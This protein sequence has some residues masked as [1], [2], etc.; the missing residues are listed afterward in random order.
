[1]RASTQRRFV[2]GPA[3][4]IECAVDQPDG[5]PRGAALIAHPHP[6][7]G[8]TLDNKVVQTLARALVELGYEA[9]RPNFR[10]IGQSEGKYDEGRGEVGDLAAVFQGLEFSNVVLAG[11]SFGAAMQARL[12][13]RLKKENQ[14]K[15]E[16]LLLVGVAVVHFETPPVP[17]DTLVIHGERDETVPLAAV[18]DWAR[19]QELP[20]V[21]VP[22]A[23]HF[24]NHK[25]HS[26][27]S[28]VSRIWR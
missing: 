6:L 28:V 16:R 13:Q 21:L 11:F 3:G 9:W 17:A 18:L 25:L 4:K 27:R 15:P 2:D 1:M 20:I 24:F 7:Y 12:A 8:G 19:P 10:G 5:S 23:D 14:P 26:L 22:G